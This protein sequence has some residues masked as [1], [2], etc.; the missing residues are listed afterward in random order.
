MA[1][2]MENPSPAVIVLIAGD[3]DYAY[4][5][6]LLRN[7][8]YSIVILPPPSGA[9]EL[10]QQASFVFHPNDLF[11]RQMVALPERTS[12]S[13]KNSARKQPSVDRDS[14]STVA[15]SVR[16]SRPIPRSTTDRPNDLD[17]TEA[18]RIVEPSKR[19]SSRSRKHPPLEAVVT[20][21]MK[22]EAEPNHRRREG[23][24]RTHI[25]SEPA[26][27]IPTAPVPALAPRS[28]SSS[29]S[30]PAPSLSRTSAPSSSN[31]TS[32][33]WVLVYP[34]ADLV[35]ILEQSEEVGIESMSRRTVKGMLMDR[36]PDILAGRYV[37]LSKLIY[38]SYTD[39]RH[40]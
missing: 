14:R 25:S 21:A 28:S 27:A 20:P 4:S 40:L 30:K 12:T 22:P 26:Q 11:G 29:T 15:R 6:S 36:N 38:I 1:F 18:P 16:S 19:S 33:P 8:R 9:D 2:A 17:V 10:L 31:S 37:L 5:V 39:L 23:S 35:D 3:R 24:R 7:H 34:F 13:Q 32:E